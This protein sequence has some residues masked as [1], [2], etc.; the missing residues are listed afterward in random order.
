M[1]P[2]GAATSGEKRLASVSFPPL[3]SR[4]EKTGC[5]WAP[6]PPGAPTSGEGPVA[7]GTP[8]YRQQWYPAEPGGSRGVPEASSA[9]PA[10]WGVAGD[11]G[12][13]GAAPG[14]RGPSRPGACGWGGGAAPGGAPVVMACGGE[15]GGLMGGPRHLRPAPTPRVL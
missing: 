3:P 2:H 9:A 6:F 4:L 7:L 14:C 10:P 1:G 5:R 12:N 13:V 11:D 15:N 8:R